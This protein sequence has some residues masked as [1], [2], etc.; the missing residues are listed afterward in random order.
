MVLPEVV[1]VIALDEL[2]AELGEAHPVL[3]PVFHAILRQ[4]V[5][6]RDVLADV[7]DEVEKAHVLEPVVVVHHA[8]CLRTFEVEEALEL[9][10]LAGQIVLNRRR[11]QELPLRRLAA[12]ISHP[13]RRTS[14]KRDGP[15]SCP[16]PM[17]QQHHG[18]QVPDV[19]RI[20]GRVKP[21]IGRHGPLC[22]RLG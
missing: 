17:Q 2:V 10:L 15:T 16:L 6:D 1:E 11:V 3:K 19:Q 7:A 20:C 9:G 12:G 18:N 14:H 21:H 5:V 22:Q 4:H 13:P 8:C